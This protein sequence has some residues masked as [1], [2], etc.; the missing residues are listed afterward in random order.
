MRHNVRLS[1]R[2]RTG[3]FQPVVGL[4]AYSLS[5]LA[6]RK[7]EAIDFHLDELPNASRIP[8]RWLSRRGTVSRRPIGYSGSWAPRSVAVPVRYRR[9]IATIGV[10]HRHPARD[11][12]MQR[13]MRASILGRRSGICVE[14]LSARTGH[15]LLDAGSSA[16]RRLAERDHAIVAQVPDSSSPRG[17]K[18]WANAEVGWRECRP[19]RAP[20]IRRGTGPAKLGSW[21]ADA[22]LHQWFSETIAY[23]SGS[24]LRTLVIRRL[25][26]CQ[27]TG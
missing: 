26:L 8:T 13:C 4:L 22:D 15:P 10:Q 5:A 17:G 1:G 19:R 7:G 27:P 6:R 24:S 16:M 23:E 14:I 11:A 25:A 2:R 9:C 21:I 12:G 18:T 3:P 20:S